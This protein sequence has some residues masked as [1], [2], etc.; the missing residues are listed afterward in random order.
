MG[1]KQ[2]TTNSSE[3]SKDKYLRNDEKYHIFLHSSNWNL[4]DSNKKL[5][6]LKDILIG[7]YHSFEY[8]EGEEFKQTV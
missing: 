6:S 8:Y 7:D 1:L 5:I 2:F 3:L 4:F